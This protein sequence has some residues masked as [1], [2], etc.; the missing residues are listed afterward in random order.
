MSKCAVNHA[1]HCANDG[2][3]Q[4]HYYC[5][6]HYRKYILAKSLAHFIAAERQYQEDLDELYKVEVAMGF[7]AAPTR[8]IVQHRVTSLERP[9]SSAARSRN[10]QHN[11]QIDEFEGEME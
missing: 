9:P 1:G 8:E 7:R 5:M 2:W 10:G 3:E 4:L 6:D 11:S